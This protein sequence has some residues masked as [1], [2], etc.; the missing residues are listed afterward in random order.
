MAAAAE[1]GNRARI[2]I[3]INNLTDPAIIGELYAA[4]QAGAEID[5]IVRAICM[6]R[7]GVDGLLLPPRDP[8]A[9]THEL[10]PLLGDRSRRRELGERGRERAREFSLQS[11]SEAVLDLYRELAGRAL[12]RDPGSIVHR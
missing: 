9:W 11:Q 10:A 1:A 6:L 4:S 2:R 3:K 12:G 5:L 7:P 8:D